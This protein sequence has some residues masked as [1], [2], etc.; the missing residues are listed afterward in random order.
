MFRVVA[1]FGFF[2]IYGLSFKL[3]SR[4][5]HFKTDIKMHEKIVVTGLGII[6]PNGNTVNTFFD[7]ICNGVSGISKLDRFDP[8]PFKCQIAG[9]IRDFNPRDYFKSKKKINQNDLY[10]HYAVAAS[11]MA[12]KDANIDLT[13]TDVDATRVGVC[14]GSAFGGMSTFEKA[15]NDL[16]QYGPNSVGPY[17]IPM[18]LGNTAAGVVAM[19]VGAK[20]PN[21]GV[22]TA[23]ATATHAMGEALRLMRNGDADVMLAGGAEAAITPLSFAG[24]CNLVAMNF[25]CND[26]PTVASRPFDLNRG[27]FVMSEGAGVIVLETL[28]HAT[29]R[30]AKI[31]CELAGYGASCDAYHITSPDPQGDGLR[32]AILACLKD[33][34]ITPEE[35]GYVNAHGTSTKKNDQFETVAF[36][37]VFGDHAKNLK[38]SSI[39][40][41]TGHSLGAAGG[42]EAIACV[43]ALETGIIPPTINYETPD[44]DCDLDYT[45]NKAV[46]VPDLK[47]ALS[48]NLGFGGHNGVVVFKKL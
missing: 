23:C 21:F 25:N 8:T 7:N 13:Q 16:T 44:P 30:G 12:M 1:V 11:S 22:Q 17:T 33:G 32:R 43:K 29:K 40:G 5:R 6:S 42:F 31:Y 14:I 2:A 3:S 18:L 35:V 28:S 48:D 39:K 26:N 20:G 34:G 24:F 38:I 27:G 41:C 10:T 4:A 46:S 15:T 19:E 37:A 47:V 36:K 45:P 9:Q